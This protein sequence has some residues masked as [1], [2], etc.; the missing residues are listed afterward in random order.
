MVQPS[1]TVSPAPRARSP[2]IAQWLKLT[3]AFIWKV[4]GLPPQRVELEKARP[5][6]TSLKVMGLFL[7]NRAVI[8]EEELRQLM[9]W[10]YWVGFCVGDEEVV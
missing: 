1:Q 9:T 6:S 4:A 2:T 8:T 5:G 10:E 7:R 3:R